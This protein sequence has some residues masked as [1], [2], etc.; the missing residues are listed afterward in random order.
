MEFEK[1][2][3]DEEEIT[4]TGKKKKIRVTDE[5]K[6]QLKQLYND[7]CSFHICIKISTFKIDRNNSRKA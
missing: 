6:L 4:K 3:I 7:V 2:N 5:R 1:E